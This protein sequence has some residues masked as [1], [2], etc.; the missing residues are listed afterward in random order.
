MRKIAV[1]T[2]VKHL[3]RV[4]ELLETKGEIFYL[5]NGTKEEVRRLILEKEV[6]TLVCN[7][8]KQGYKIDEEERTISIWNAGNGFSRL[9][10]Y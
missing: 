9:W 5:E 7:P 4:P 8:N 6:N 2:P 1:I 10:T 3:P